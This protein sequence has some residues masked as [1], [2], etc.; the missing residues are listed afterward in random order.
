MSLL[1]LAKHRAV[2]DTWAPGVSRIEVHCCQQVPVL[3]AA[4]VVKNGAGTSISDIEN[5]PELEKG[6]LYV[7]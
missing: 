5:Q 2:I 6:A 1:G 4:T 3:F 7:R